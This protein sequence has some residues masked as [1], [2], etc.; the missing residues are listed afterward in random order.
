MPGQAL[1]DPLGRGSI[2]FADPRERSG[3]GGFH[4]AGANRV[5]PPPAPGQAENG[6]ATVARVIH[7]A[8]ELLRRQ[9]LENPGQR[10]GVDVHDG[11]EISG[12]EPRQQADDPQHQPLRPG[13]A[14][15]TAHP[16]RRAL[17]AVHHGPEQ[18]HEFQDIRQCRRR[19]CGSSRYLHA[20]FLPRIV[21]PA[22]GTRRRRPV[23]DDLSSN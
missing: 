16:L 5:H 8:E 2:D 7:P 6:A 21:D 4:G 23:D 13:N 19:R 12:R 1:E 11:G 18:L 3:D 9:A 22:A 17:E 20:R 15:R 10:A 14:E